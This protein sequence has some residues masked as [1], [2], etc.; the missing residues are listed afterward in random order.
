MLRKA[1]LKYQTS[2]ALWFLGDTM[3]KPSTNSRQQE[4]FFLVAARNISVNLWAI[5]KVTY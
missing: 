4:K 3:A 1:E 5:E 2:E